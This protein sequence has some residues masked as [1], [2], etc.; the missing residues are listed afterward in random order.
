VPNAHPLFQKEH[1]ARWPD[2]IREGS[3]PRLRDATGQYHDAH[4]ATD[5]QQLTQIAVYIEKSKLPLGDGEL[6]CFHDST[7]P[8]YLLLDRRPS[9][10]YMHFGTVLGLR[11]HYDDVRRKLAESRQK[12]VV[13]DL[14][15]MTT[16][17]ER[18]N[19]PAP[20]GEENDLPAWL[21]ASERLKFPWNQPVIFRCGRYTLHEVRNP[22]GEI[23]IPNWEQIH[24]WESAK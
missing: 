11:H 16:Q 3:S 10:R 5:W 20:N 22:I 18:A 23:D 17:I 4:C 1:W 14:G 21:P 8:L 19:E 2:C 13:S 24:K 7:H 9:T 12:Y 15:R 6:T